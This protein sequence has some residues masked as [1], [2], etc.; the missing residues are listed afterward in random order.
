[1]REIDVDADA[2]AGHAIAGSVG[3]KALHGAILDRVHICEL[4][5]AAAD[6]AFEHRRDRP[7]SPA[8]VDEEFLGKYRILS[9]QHRDSGAAEDCSGPI[10]ADAGLLVQCLHAAP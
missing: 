10:V 4:Q 9:D 8:Q 2:D 7:S 6:M 3:R 5:H 1:M